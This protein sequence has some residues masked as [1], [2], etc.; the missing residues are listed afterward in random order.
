[1]VV[2]FMSSGEGDAVRFEAAF[3][4]LHVPDASLAMVVLPA[5]TTADEAREWVSEI[6]GGEP[7]ETNGD[8]PPWMAEAYTI[9]GEYSGFAALGGR[10]GRWFYFVA[11]YPPEFGDGIGPRIDLILS[12]WRWPDGSGLSTPDR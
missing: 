10:G 7:R 11:S 12:R 4:G 5:G 2:E 1:M 8:R 9:R 3:A 6:A